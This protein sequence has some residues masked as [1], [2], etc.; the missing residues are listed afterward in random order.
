VSPYKD[1]TAKPFAAKHNFAFVWE[2]IMKK[3]VAGT[4]LGLIAMSGAAFA[5]GH[6]VSA[7]LIPKT[8]T[9]PFFVKLREGAQAK[10]A[11]LGLPLTAYPG[12]VDG[13]NESQAHRIGT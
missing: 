10:A 7:C 5:D 9:N 12:Q 4:A 6:G 13:A 1:V 11:D 8:D 2:D 3:L